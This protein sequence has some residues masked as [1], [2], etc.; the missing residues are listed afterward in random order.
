MAAIT[1][2]LASGVTVEYGRAARFYS[3]ISSISAAR[4]ERRDTP[5]RAVAEQFTAV[6]PPCGVYIYIILECRARGGD[7]CK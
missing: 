2:F 5:I 3:D 7:H 4:G 6:R 1:L